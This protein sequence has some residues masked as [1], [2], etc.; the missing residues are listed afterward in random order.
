MSQ[1]YVRVHDWPESLR[2]WAEKI[3]KHITVQGKSGT[4]TGIVKKVAP[5]GAYLTMRLDAPE[6]G[7]ERATLNIPLDGLRVTRTDW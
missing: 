1:T 2:P 3:G 5:T 4:W 7:D 6:P